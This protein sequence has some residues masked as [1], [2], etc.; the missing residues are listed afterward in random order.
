MS[1]GYLNFY[2]NLT[3]DSKLCFQQSGPVGMDNI[4][5]GIN[6]V[7]LITTKIFRRDREK[8]KPNNFL[9]FFKKIAPMDNS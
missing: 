3:H 2:L 1:Y 4:K 7:T 5:L 6:L 8:K 9:Y